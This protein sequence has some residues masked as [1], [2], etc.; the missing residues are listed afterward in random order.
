MGLFCLFIKKHS[1]ILKGMFI[2]RMIREYTLLPVNPLFK[3]VQCII[4]HFGI[5]PTPGKYIASIVD[6]NN[7]TDTFIL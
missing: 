6:T 1:V 7:N 2:F 5:D 3:L 4:A